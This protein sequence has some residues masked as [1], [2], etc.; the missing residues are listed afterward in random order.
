MGL[1]GNGAAVFRQPLRQIGGGFAGDLPVWGRSE[2]ANRSVGGLAGVFSAYPSGYLPSKTPL[3]PRKSGAIASRLKIEGVS[4]LA[5]S[6][7]MGVN[8]E[9]AIAGA[10]SIAAALQLV[11]SA[12]ASL[13]GVGG[14]NGNLAGKLEAVAALAGSGSVS[15]AIGALAGVFSTISSAGG[16]NGTARALGLMFADI[17]PFT[18]LSPQSL[19]AAVWDKV[20]ESGLTAEDA[21][22][23]IAAATAG[24]I[25]GGGTTT[26]TIRN[27]VAD[28]KNRIVATVDD[29]GNRTAL[30][31]DLTD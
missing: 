1:V 24:E 7:A 21:M 22:K 11:V 17:T 20:I 8:A 13:A 23:L 18:E 25:S 29:D 12:A 6:G 5:S 30:T 16:L 28:S 3:L 2:R 10:G 15:A 27:A 26:V 4:V 14:L 9:T 19:A 31:Y